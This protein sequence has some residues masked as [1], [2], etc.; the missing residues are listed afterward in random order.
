M[1]N[2]K[3]T[4]NV[5]SGRLPIALSALAV[6]LLVLALTTGWGRGPPGDEGAAAHLWQL[7]VGLQIPLIVAFV[8][9]ADWR[10]PLGPLAI[11]GLQVLALM[12]AMAPV[13]VLR[14]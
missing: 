9:T 12:I 3:R 11:L 8:A 4:I 13:A 14:L 2:A 6:G 1:A 7:L 10:R 5:W